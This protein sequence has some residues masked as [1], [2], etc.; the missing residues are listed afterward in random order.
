[1]Y[2]LF[3]LFFFL[4]LCFCFLSCFSSFNKKITNSRLIIGGG[5][6]RGFAPILIIGGAYPGCRPRVYAYAYA[7]SQ[8][9]EISGTLDR[10]RL[11]VI[12]YLS[13][14]YTFSYL[15][16][17]T[18]DIGI[19]PGGWRVATPR[20]RAGGSLGCLLVVTGAEGGRR[21]VM[22]G[23]RNISIPILDRKYV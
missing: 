16:P 13:H 14:H 11:L 23:S 7:Q 4:C 20:S 9:V 1:M 8:C 12:I 3:F 21:V 22:D 18:V 15:K 10:H 2:S 6:K 5:Q 19:N 17:S